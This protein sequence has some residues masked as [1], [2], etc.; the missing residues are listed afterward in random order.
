MRPLGHDARN[1]RDI[2]QI[3]FMRQPLHGNGLDEWIRNND[4]FLARRRR[5]AVKRGFHIRLQNF[6]DARQA[7]EEFHRQL[8]RFLGNVFFGEAVGRMIF[9]ALAD[10]VLQFARIES[11]SAAVSTLISDEWIS[12]SSKNP[13]N[14]SR[15]KS[16]AMAVTTRLDGRFLPSR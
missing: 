12:L 6:A 9:Q 3:Q 2:F 5:V 4:L 11:S 16:C 10:F 7:A 14:S 13:G 8:V 15:S 1:E